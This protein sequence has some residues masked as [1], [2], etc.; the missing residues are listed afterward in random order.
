[1]LFRFSGAFVDEESHDEHADGDEYI[2]YFVAVSLNFQDKL[3]L[4]NDRVE[5]ISNGGQYDV[6]AHGSQGGEED[7]FRE[8]HAGQTGGNGDELSHGGD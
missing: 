3:V 1:M 4:G 5:S 2:E 8:L 7:K 6:P